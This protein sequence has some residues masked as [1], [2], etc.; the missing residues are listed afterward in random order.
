MHA[1]DRGDEPPKLRAV[2]EQ[3]TPQWVRY[4]RNGEGKKPNDDHWRKFQPHLSRAFSAICGYCERCCKGQ[5]DH[6]RPKSRHPELVYAWSNWILACPTCN[7]NKSEK[8]PRGGYVDP[9]AKTRPAQPEAYFTFDTLTGELI[10]RAGLS[11]QRRKKAF[12]MIEDLGLNAY[13]HQKERVQWLDVLEA[14]LR[15]E[16]PDDPDHAEFIRLVAGRDAELSSITRT[17]LTEHGYA[18]PEA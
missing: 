12:Q 6:F 13:Y 15:G 1:V 4:Y 5:V 16:D 11:P 3:Y 2:R 9:C 10:P 18:I 14:A 7:Q 8:W 17:F